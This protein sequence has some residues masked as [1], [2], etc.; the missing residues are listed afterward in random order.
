MVPRQDVERLLGVTAR[1]AQRILAS[2]GATIQGKVAVISGAD[3]CLYL[4]HVGGPEVAAAAKLQRRGFA[5][6]LH[7]MRKERLEC[8]APILVEIQE[9]EARAIRRI[10]YG[11][12]PEGVDL[13]PETLTIQFSSPEDLI[14]KLGMLALALQA[15]SGF[16]GL[17]RMMEQGRL[18][19][20]EPAQ[21][22]GR[23]QL[24]SS[25]TAGS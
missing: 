3:L 14:Q 19:L 5:V 8:G 2:A 16:Q 15:D 13:E 25:Y 22:P 6:K 24:G 23:S 1:Q 7:Q 18:N 9:K 4:E 12:L 20:G 17:E 10:G 11:A 21:W